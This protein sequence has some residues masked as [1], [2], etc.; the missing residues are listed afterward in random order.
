MFLSDVFVLRC[1]HSR[2]LCNHESACIGLGSA[3]MVVCTCS[4]NNWPGLRYLHFRFG[5][6]SVETNEYSLLVAEHR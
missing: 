5:L 4:S 1:L 2:F 6:L 3:L